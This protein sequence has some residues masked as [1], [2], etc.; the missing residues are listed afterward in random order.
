MPAMLYPDTTRIDGDIGQKGEI[1]IVIVIVKVI[2]QVVVTAH[3][4]CNA[5]SRY[6]SEKTVTLDKE[7]VPELDLQEADQ[8]DAMILNCLQ[9]RAFLGWLRATHSIRTHS[10]E[11]TF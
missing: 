2:V 8:L 3:D 5:L 11:N 7:Y 9:V 4:A 6:D 10:I 1:A